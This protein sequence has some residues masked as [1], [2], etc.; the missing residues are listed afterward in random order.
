MRRVFEHE[1]AVGGGGVGAKAAPALGHERADAGEFDG[2]EDELGEGV[3]V[4]DDDRAEADV[5]GGRAGGE[6][7]GEV[8][9]RRVGR[10]EVEEDE[11][12]EGDF[13]SPVFGLGDEGG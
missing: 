5:N 7:G 1:D 3:G 2:F 4:V 12:G 6:K 13:G 9:G 8:V 11:A 10:C